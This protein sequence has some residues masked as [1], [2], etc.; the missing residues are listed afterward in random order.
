MMQAAIQFELPIPLDYIE[1]TIPPGMAIAEYRRSRPQRTS[2]WRR[3][4]LR[5]G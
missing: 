1:T 2:W 5:R 3:L 4:Q